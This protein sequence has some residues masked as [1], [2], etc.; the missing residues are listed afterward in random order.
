MAPNL[1][2]W[3]KNG[4]KRP[5]FGLVTQQSGRVYT[6]LHSLLSTAVQRAQVVLNRL[7]GPELDLHPAVHGVVRGGSTAAVLNNSK[8]MDRRHSNNKL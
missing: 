8:S 2:L 1:A 5:T 4:L 7:S 3:R 6:N